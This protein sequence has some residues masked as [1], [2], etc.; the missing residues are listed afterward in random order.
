MKRI[1]SILAVSILFSASSFAAKQITREES[2]GYT[3]IGELSVKQS[4]T[5]TVGHKALSHK[6]DKKCQELGDVKASDCYY[7]IIDKTG[8][9]TNHENIDLEIFKK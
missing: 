5:P 3:K 7:L 6:V 9:E 8:N 1:I 2:S 4:G